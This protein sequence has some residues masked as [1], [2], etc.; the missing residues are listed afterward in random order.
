M[1]ADQFK[2]RLIAEVNRR[3]MEQRR[4]Q[5]AVE[6]RSRLVQSR[7]ASVLPSFKYVGEYVHTSAGPWAHVTGFGAE[8][9]G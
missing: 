5:E 6:R 9:G 3:R 4:S 8:I 1:M 2:E 7:V